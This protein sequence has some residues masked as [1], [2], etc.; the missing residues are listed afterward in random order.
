MLPPALPPAWVPLFRLGY[1]LLAFVV[2]W[3]GVRLRRA[4]PWEQRA[5]L[6]AAGVQL[7][8]AIALDAAG[9]AAGLW[10]YAVHDG[11]LIGVPLDLH[12]AW[13]LLWGLLFVHWA[14]RQLASALRYAAVWW[15]AT[16]T[17]DGILAPHAQALVRRSAGLSW[18]M[19][20]ALMIACLLLVALLVQRAVRQSGEALSRGS[21]SIGELQRLRLGAALRAGLYLVAF[22]AISFGLLPYLI[23]TL[24]G[25][26]VWPPPL[27]AVLRFSLVG[28]GALC[29]LWP[30]WAVLEFVRAGGTPLPFD[31][32]LALVT[33]GPYA[34]VRNPMQLG[35]IAAVLAMAALYRSVWLLAYAVDLVLV[36]QLFFLPQE[37]AEL[38]RRF[39][40]VYVRYCL[41][42]RCWLPRLWPYHEPDEPPLV[43]GYDQSC[44]ACVDTVAKLPR[45]LVGPA[46]VA[47]PLPEGGRGFCVSAPQ[48]GGGPPVLHHGMDAWLA[49]LQR[50]P[51]FIACLVP[52]FSLPPLR[53]LLRL[54][55]EVAAE[56]RP[57]HQ[58]GAANR[59][60]GIGV[61]SAEP[62]GRP[63][64][65]APP[66]AESQARRPLAGAQ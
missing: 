19:G 45:L 58:R 41:A 2:T 4:T 14:P 17:Y 5:A 37:E 15:V 7:V 63:R 53:Q 49:L 38:R 42:V 31:P 9:Q 29:L 60:I 8:L 66:D 16:L 26:G 59:S 6:V 65:A 43:V 55:Y 30:L 62:A 1:L 48:S 34:F 12:L 54:C 24:S 57:R 27:P 22:G 36:S 35:A 3:V 64:A 28:A 50:G 52:L 11:L 20:D 46:L 51:I 56:Q 47:A 10:R 21:L 23:L 40:A 32:P 13:A 44:P 61:S 25:Q 18:L 39:G 33:S